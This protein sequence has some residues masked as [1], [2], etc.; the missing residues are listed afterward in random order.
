MYFLQFPTT[1][2]QMLSENKDICDFCVFRK[3]VNTAISS[4]IP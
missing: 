4:Y 1:Q 3:V 2:I